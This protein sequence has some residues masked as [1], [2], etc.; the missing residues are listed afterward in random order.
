ML[1]KIPAARALIL[2]GIVFSVFSTTVTGQPADCLSKYRIPGPDTHNM[3]K[4]EKVISCV[5]RTGAL[6]REV[7]WQGA[8]LAGTSMIPRQPYEA[9]ELFMG[10]ASLFESGVGN[11]SQTKIEAAANGRYAVLPALNDLKSRSW[12][13]GRE[14]FFAL[15]GINF[16]DQFVYGPEGNYVR[17]IAP[18][19]SHQNIKRLANALSDACDLYFGAKAGG[20]EDATLGDAIGLAAAF[21]KYRN[22]FPADFT[23]DRGQEERLPFPQQVYDGVFAGIMADMAKEIPF[24][25]A[26]KKSMSDRGLAAEDI[27]AAPQKF[28]EAALLGLIS[29]DFY[30]FKKVRGSGG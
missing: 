22:L 2:A 14:R 28:R 15:T 4:A 30:R 6:D 29:S 24:F 21:L 10:F 9:F 1:K 16:R 8:G 5:V 17:V 26:L 13:S 7:W 12:V 23:L 3:V 18:L 25:Y 19:P 20:F 11:N 27:I